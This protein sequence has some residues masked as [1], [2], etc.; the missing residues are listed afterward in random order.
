MGGCVNIQCS[1]GS[2]LGDNRVVTAMLN[3]IVM[4]EAQR[5]DA[6]RYL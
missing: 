4:E 1:L 5:S 6:C 2:D 3:D